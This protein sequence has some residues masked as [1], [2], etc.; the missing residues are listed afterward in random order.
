MFGD[1]DIFPNAQTSLRDPMGFVDLSG[2]PIPVRED[3]ANCDV[4]ANAG[5]QQAS[6]YMP[7]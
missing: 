3:S 5:C 7:C 2:L 1:S 6:R 4:E